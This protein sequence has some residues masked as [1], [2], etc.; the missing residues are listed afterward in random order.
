MNKLDNATK[1]WNTIKE[2]SVRDI[3]VESRRPF[4]MEVDSELI[5]RFDPNSSGSK[6]VERF[7]DV[8]VASEENTSSSVTIGTSSDDLIRISIQNRRSN[9]LETTN[10]KVYVVKEIGDID[11]TL[12]RVLED[13]PQIALSIAR[14]VPIFRSVL[15][16]QVIHDTAMANAEYA[17][18]NALP[19]VVPIIA[20]LLPA[21]AIGDIFMLTKNQGMMMFKLAAMYDQSLDIRDRSK[22]ITSILGNSIGWRAI[23][24]EVAG[25][26]PGGVGLLV[27]GALAY[28]GTYAAGM[29]LEEFYA[30]GLRPTQAKLK[31][32][33]KQAYL[34]ALETMKRL[35]PSARS[36]KRKRIGFTSVADTER[37]N[38]S[39][40]AT[41]NKITSD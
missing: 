15:A 9:P 10:L 23:A 7:S 3:S 32:Y 12:R 36:K 17:M 1:F 4:S 28:A 37:L 41:D 2:V 39:L 16:K 20:P 5:S 25:I 22:E 14:T 34:E 26:V 11:R 18:L 19:G 38:V 29:A 31:S 30:T 21:T 40:P 35:T 24:R 13:N 33:Y 8:V 27:R 6:S